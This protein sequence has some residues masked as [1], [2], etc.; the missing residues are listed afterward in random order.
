MAPHCP[1]DPHVVVRVVLSALQVAVQLTPAT[2]SA[3]PVSQ[4]ADPVVLTVPSGLSGQILGQAPT[5]APHCPSDPQVVLTGVPAPSPAQVAEQTVPSRDVLQVPHESA[6]EPVLVR[7]SAGAPV[8]CA[9]H[10]PSAVLLQVPLDSQ[11]TIAL[12]P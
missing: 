1:P 8:H 3:Q 4:L 9:K 12:P 11:V 7:E 2:L 10:F 5:V 6:G